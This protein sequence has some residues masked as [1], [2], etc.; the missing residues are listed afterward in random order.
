MKI[1]VEYKEG[2]ENMAD[3][4]LQLFQKIRMVE[5]RK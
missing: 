3:K 2:L 5:V 1:Q 4:N